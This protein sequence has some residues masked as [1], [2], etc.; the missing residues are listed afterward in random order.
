VIHFAVQ[1]PSAIAVSKLSTGE[2][3]IRPASSHAVAL[4]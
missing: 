3:T 2:Q 4:Q 1:P